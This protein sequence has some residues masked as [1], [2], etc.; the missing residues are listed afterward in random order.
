MGKMVV[1]RP[2]IYSLEAWPASGRTKVRADADMC[3][4]EGGDQHI[5]KVA[6]HFDFRILSACFAGSRTP[7]GLVRG[8]QS[9]EGWLPEP[10]HGDRYT[11]CRLSSSLPVTFDGIAWWV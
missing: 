9:G 8:A 2:C 10:C 11:C 6:T 7:H 3:D 4:A 5:P 1:A